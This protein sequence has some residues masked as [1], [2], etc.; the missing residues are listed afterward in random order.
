MDFAQIEDRVRLELLR[1]IERGT[2]S[3]S[4]LARQTGLGQPHVSNFLRLRRQLSHRALD[5]ILAAQRLDLADVM[6]ARRE[7]FESLLGAPSTEIARIPLVSQSAA[8]FEPHIRPGG[9]Q[10]LIP[11]AGLTVGGFLARCGSARRQWERFVAVRISA[12][13]AQPMEPEVRGRAIVLLDRHYT[14]LKFYREAERNLYGIRAGAGMVVRYVEFAANR[15]I[16][17]PRRLEFGLESIEVEGEETASSLVVGRVVVV[18][19]EY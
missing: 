10:R 16:L 13:E 11:F 2:L 5:K 3:V 17:R 8:M 19:N 1:R 9:V 15:L 6:P 7:G 12:E 14:S 18:V 4:L